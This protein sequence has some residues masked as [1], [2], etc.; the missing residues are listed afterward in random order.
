MTSIYHDVL[1]KFIDKLV[2]EGKHFVQKYQK[3]SVEFLIHIKLLIL[4][5]ITYYVFV[6]RHQRRKT[7]QSRQ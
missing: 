6:C 7:V 4:F 3:I 5:Y 1:F 2:A